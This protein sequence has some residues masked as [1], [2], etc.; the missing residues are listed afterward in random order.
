MSDL[1]KLMAT[2]NVSTVGQIIGDEGPAPPQGPFS[3]ARLGDTPPFPEPGIYFDMPEEE[4][5]AIPALSSSG[6]K[7]LAASPMLFWAKTGWLNPDKEEAE[8]KE[9]QALGKAYHCRILEGKAAFADRFRIGMDKADYPDALESTDEIKLAIGEAGATA[10][11]RIGTGTFAPNAKGVEK[12]VTRAARKEDWIE[13]LLEL[14]PDVQIWS[15]ITS[16]FGADNAGKTFVTAEQL[17]R[18]EIAAAMI[19]RDPEL[20]KAMAGGYPEV[21]LFWYC[22]RTGVPMKARADR[23]KTR[24]I[25]DLKTIANQN[26]MSIERAIAREIANRKYN[27]QPSVYFEGADQVRKLVRA[28]GASVV[29]GTRDAVSW[30]LKWAQHSD[31]DQFLWIFQQKGVAPV[32]RGLFYP[33]G[34]TTKMVTDDIVTAQ[35]RRFRNFSE[36]YGIEPWLDIASIYDIADEDIPPWSTEI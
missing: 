6:V 20:S 36:T 28:G 14:N 27:I 3:P 26:E 7:L 13:Q 22:A 31:P 5:H 18:I 32:T 10:V 35:K 9:H 19:E 15:R 21:S 25:V 30:A 17:K 8:D 29:H 11:S 2:G 23:L 1:E 4:Y 16:Q 34:G 33:R 24:A 12:E